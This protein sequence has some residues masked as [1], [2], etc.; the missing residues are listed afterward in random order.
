M[1]W[2]AV[3]V[4]C[5]ALLLQ[6][7]NSAPAAER[8]A[9]SSGG[10]E[11]S[12]TRTYLIFADVTQSLTNEEQQRVSERVGKIV[13]TIPPRSRLYVFPILEDVPRAPA[14]FKGDLPAIRGTSDRVLI[15]G[16]R[17]KWQTTISEELKKINQGP[18]IGRKR[19]CVSGAL[20][21]ASEIVSSSNPAE[22]VLVSDMLEDC[23][24]SLFH[25]PL[26]LEKADI[27]KELEL[28]HGVAKPLLDLHNASVT[29][30]LT[31]VPTSQP[32]VASPPEPDLREFWRTILDNCNDRKDNFSFSTEIP[33]RFEAKR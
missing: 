32:H 9:Q 18:G 29:V 31:T 22:I 25:K 6:C 5:C 21:K 15:D 24:S 26:T 33:E 20:Q 13:A 4:V 7:G 11:S 27:G 23:P 30:L 14:I 19:T 16:L 17:L 3:L 2:R 28:A 1:N 12:G 10:G 8:S